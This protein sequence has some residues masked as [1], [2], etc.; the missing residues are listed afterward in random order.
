MG[1]LF[2]D[3]VLYIILQLL[4]GSAALG[5]N[6]IA[7]ILGLLVILLAYYVTGLVFSELKLGFR[8]IGLGVSKSLFF[9]WEANRIRYVAWSY[10]CE[11]PPQGK[12][13]TT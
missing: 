6:V 12:R 2:G 1:G 13:Y 8:T 11:K 10:Y 7:V 3:T 4:P 9:Y 5:A